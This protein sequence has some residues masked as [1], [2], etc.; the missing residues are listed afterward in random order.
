MGVIQHGLME[1]FVPCTVKP[2]HAWVQPLLVVACWKAAPEEVVDSPLSFYVVS[3]QQTGGGKFI[4][5]K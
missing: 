5:P 4:A 2:S 1:W 3:D